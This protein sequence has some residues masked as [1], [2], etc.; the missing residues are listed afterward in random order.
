MSESLNVHI[1]IDLSRAW[2]IFGQNS[3]ISGG[4]R[5]LRKVLKSY[6]LELS[7]EPIHHVCWGPTLWRIL[8]NSFWASRTSHSKF[9]SSAPKIL[10]KSSEFQYK[11]IRKI[12]K[13]NGNWR[14]S[15][16]IFGANEPNFE[17]LVLEAQKELAKILQRVGPPAHMMVLVHRRV[18][19]CKIWSPYDAIKDLHW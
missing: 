11:T 1:M 6:S 9:G 14:G 5:S 18:P 19:G 10:S 2:T 15:G 17:R 7:C 4:L 3:S 12:P 8:A 16:S 13:S